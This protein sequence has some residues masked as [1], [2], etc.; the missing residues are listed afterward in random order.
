MGRGRRVAC[1]H[2]LDFPWVP[3]VGRD[4]SLLRPLRAFADLS[5]KLT[6]NATITP[7]IF[8]LSLVVQILIALSL[9]TGALA[10][11]VTLPPAAILLVPLLIFVGNL[12]FS[13]AGWGLREGAMITGFSL[14]ALPATEA[15]S[16]SILHGLTQL[17][18]GLPGIYLV[19]SQFGLNSI[20]QA[21]VA[22]DDLATDKDLR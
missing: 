18:I 3:R 5:N 11:N 10:L 20:R 19:V 4:W 2:G 7:Q 16:I 6:R 17:L 14:F 9:Y 21:E 1:V 15:L 12:P 8:G 22:Q 13:F